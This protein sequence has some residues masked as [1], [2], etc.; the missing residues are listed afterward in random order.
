MNVPSEDTHAWVRRAA[1]R[2]MNAADWFPDRT[3]SI[4]N[5]QA[6]AV[7][8]TRC[9]VRRECAAE[10]QPTDQGIWGGQWWPIHKIPADLRKATL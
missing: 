6:I 9:V 7:C 4:A 5:R 3:L 1:C 2:G 10:R 8:L